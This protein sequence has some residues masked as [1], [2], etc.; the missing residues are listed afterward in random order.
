MELRQQPI[1]LTGGH[2][3]TVPAWSEGRKDERDYVRFHWSPQLDPRQYRVAVS[4]SDASSPS[5]LTIGPLRE[6]VQLPFIHFCA[7]GLISVLPVSDPSLPR[8]VG[9]LNRASTYELPATRISGTYRI[10]PQGVMTSS[11]NPL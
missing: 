9:R 6:R 8:F 3:M 10:D 5:W 7:E 2:F 1:L 4:A 11:V